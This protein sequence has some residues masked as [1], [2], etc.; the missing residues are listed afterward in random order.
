VLQGQDV[1][2]PFDL[3]ETVGKARF[4]VG[5]GVEERPVD[6]LDLCRA[7]VMDTA[8]MLD[9]GLLV[10]VGKGGAAEMAELGR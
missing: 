9:L 4:L 3:E 1:V 6:L 10:G 2:D 5:N 7:P 8:Q